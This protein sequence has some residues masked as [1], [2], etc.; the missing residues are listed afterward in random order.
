[1]HYGLFADRQK[2]SNNIITIKEAAKIL[3]MDRKVLSAGIKAGAF[4]EF[5]K[6]WIEKGKLKIIIFR[7]KLIKFKEGKI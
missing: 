1:M 6:K 2:M 3:D 4:P 7:D 5:S